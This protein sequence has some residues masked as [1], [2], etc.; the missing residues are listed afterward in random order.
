MGELQALLL[1][2]HFL[3]T[4]RRDVTQNLFWELE[5]EYLDTRLLCM[6]IKTYQLF[7]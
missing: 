7:P 5:R 3:K 6:Y 2:A 4:E 1:A